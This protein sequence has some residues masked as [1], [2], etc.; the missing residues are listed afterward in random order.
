[1]SLGVHGPAIVILTMPLVSLFNKYHLSS[2][3]SLCAVFNDFVRNKVYM[4]SLDELLIESQIDR[5][6]HSYG[7]QTMH[8][9]LA[10]Q[11]IQVAE[12]RVSRSMSRVAPGP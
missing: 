5:V 4:D 7:R 12:D 6:G 10:A 1:M 2:E 9:L 11:G 3:V 8:G